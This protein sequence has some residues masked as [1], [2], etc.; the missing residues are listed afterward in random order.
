MKSVV[1][2]WFFVLEILVY[3]YFEV[4]IVYKSL[5]GWLSVG[6]FFNS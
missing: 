5:V 1:R 6:S 3:L 4:V 2:N